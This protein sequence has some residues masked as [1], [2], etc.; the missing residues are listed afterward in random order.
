MQ[1]CQ[2]R[3]SADFPSRTF[4][5]WVWTIAETQEFNFGPSTLVGFAFVVCFGGDRVGTPNKF[6]RCLLICAS[7]LSPV[8]DTKWEPLS[9][10]IQATNQGGENRCKLIVWA[11]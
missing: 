6:A 3:F 7:E 9:P 1:R 10:T 11:F 5:F 4:T 2:G 8:P